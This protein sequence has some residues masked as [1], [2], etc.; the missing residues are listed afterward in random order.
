MFKQDVYEYT[1]AR[2]GEM[3]IEEERND[4]SKSKMEI[5]HIGVTDD[6]FE[7]GVSGSH[8]FI[9]GYVGKKK[10]I[11]LPDTIEGHRYSIGR[12]AFMLYDRMTTLVIPDSVL[13]IGEGA[14]SSCRNL[15]ELTLPVSIDAVA[16]NKLPAFGNCKRITKITFTRGDGHYFGYRIGLTEVF[17][18]YNGEANT[19]WVISGEALKEIYLPSDIDYLGEWLHRS[20]PSLE[21][22]MVR[23]S[24]GHLT[25]C[26]GVLFDDGQRVL[27]RYPERKTGTFFEIP[28]DC[29]YMCDG[30]FRGCS[31]LDEISIPESITDLGW[32]VF[33]EC[34]NLKTVRLPQK[35]ERIPSFAFYG[36]T[37]LE[38]VKMPDDLH[39][40]SDEA[41]NG[42]S[43]LVSAE[44][45]QSV[46]D[47][48]YKA[49]AGCESLVNVILPDNVS[50]GKYAF[51][52]CTGIR[53]LEIPQN[54]SLDSQA[55]EG[56][57]FCD[58]DGI[59]L[60]E[61]ELNGHTFVG[62]DGNMRMI[63]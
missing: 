55:F 45:P 43:S 13:S 48:G 11:V 40:I 9:T 42:C 32:G 22:I 19:P 39:I 27:V 49:F 15:K 8:Y 3:T 34:S 61:N 24:R 60:S 36:C 37:G 29:E 12:K 28:D 17:S 21:K 38:Y 20:L 33:R 63:R 18:E 2:S 35:I 7:Y 58:A 50:V 30:A 5:K 57:S 16:S 10:K 62:Q 31:E 51:S 46:S 4:A 56:I 53:I 1:S 6:G 54:V 26:D 41:F 23:D 14:F 47:I 25:S 44:I 52:E 59:A